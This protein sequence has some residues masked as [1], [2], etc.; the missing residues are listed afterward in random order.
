MIHDVSFVFICCFSITW[1]CCIHHD[2]GI[3]KKN[4]PLKPRKWYPLVSEGTCWKSL[5]LSEGVACLLPK[6]FPGGGSL[7]N[8][9]V[10]L[11][12]QQRAVDE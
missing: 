4:L 9:D 8:C 2:V 5:K 11:A 7:R 3:P 6:R 10:H 1:S 12:V